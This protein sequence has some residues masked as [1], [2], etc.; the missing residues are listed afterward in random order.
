[1]VQLFYISNAVE[2]SLI[3]E[4]IL[5]SVVQPWLVKYELFVYKNL[6]WFCANR[7]LSI[8]RAVKTGFILKILGTDF[9][10][11]WENISAFSVNYSRSRVST[12]AQGL[13]RAIHAMEH[14]S[15]RFICP[16]LRQQLLAC[17]S[18]LYES[19]SKYKRAKYIPRYVL[20]KIFHTR[21][22]C[23]SGLFF[24]QL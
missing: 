13:M 17:V 9:V 4:V 1:M 20:H 2:D 5:A 15:G 24:L 7:S 3:D 18:Q 8:L 21:K 6:N 23:S 11:L 12:C 16:V 22:W 10:S 14:V 19:G